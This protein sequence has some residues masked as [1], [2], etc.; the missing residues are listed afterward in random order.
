MNSV[1]QN[2]LNNNWKQI[3]NLFFIRRHTLRADYIKYF[4]CIMHH[5]VIVK[6]FISY[7]TTKLYYDM[8]GY[9]TVNQIQSEVCHPKR[10]D[11]PRKEIEL[12]LF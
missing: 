5:V 4:Q 7:T 6:C 11:C 9:I 3:H 2:D 10:L 1:I 8:H 12:K